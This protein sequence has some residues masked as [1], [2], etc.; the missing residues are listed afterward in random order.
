[1]GTRTAQA[2]VYPDGLYDAI[3]QSVHRIS[4]MQSGGRI[5]IQTSQLQGKDMI[6]SVSSILSELQ[7]KAKR[8]GRTAAWDLSPPSDILA[9]AA[10]PACRTGLPWRVAPVS[11]L[12]PGEL[13]WLRLSEQAT[14]SL[15]ICRLRICR[16]P[17]RWKALS[18]V[19]WSGLIC[20][21]S[22]P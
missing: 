15:R 16:R 5:C 4:T 10:W 12:C 6:Q 13:P 1:M 7:V 19:A 14:R 11:L 8:Q 21:D 18:L 20:V 3:L 17:F 9:R 2:A 22:S